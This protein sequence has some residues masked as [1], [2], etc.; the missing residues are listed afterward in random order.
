MATTGFF[1]DDGDGD[2]DGDADGGMAAVESGADFC[3]KPFAGGILFDMTVWYKRGAVSR[4][5]HKK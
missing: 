5:V 2:G 4:Y 3:D 1:E